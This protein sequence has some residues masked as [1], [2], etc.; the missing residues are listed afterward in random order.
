MNNAASTVCKKPQ[1][2]S[3]FLSQQHYRPHCSDLTHGN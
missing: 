1:S 3:L 2:M